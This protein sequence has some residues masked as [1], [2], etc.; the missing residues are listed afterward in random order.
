MEEPS[1]L[2]LGTF[3][4]QQQ[5]QSSRVNCRTPGASPFARQCTSLAGATSSCITRHLSGRRLCVRC[6]ALHQGGCLPVRRTA[7]SRPRSTQ[8]LARQCLRRSSG[9]PAAHVRSGRKPCGQGVPGCCLQQVRSISTTASTSP[10]V[11]L[12]LCVQAAELSRC[13]LTRLGTLCELEGMRMN[14]PWPLCIAGVRLPAAEGE[15]GCARCRCE[16][17]HQALV[18]L[19]L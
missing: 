13:R 7:A 17:P 2:W 4:A 8:V 18:G 16:H 12:S 14:L 1:Y 19:Q 3:F 5:A 10:V 9:S 6:S 15:I 11:H